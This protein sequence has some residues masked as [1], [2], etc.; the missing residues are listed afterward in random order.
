MICCL[1][2]VSNAIVQDA[3]LKS[4]DRDVS[5]ETIVT[6]SDTSAPAAPENATKHPGLRRIL[7]LAGPVV[8]ILVGLWLYLSGGQYVTEDD[9]YVGAANVTITPQVSGQVIRV[10]VATNQMVQQDQLLF[11]IDPEPFQIALDRA[12]ANLAEAS[13]KLQGLLLTYNQDQASVAQS[14]ADVTF[15]QQEFD[16][17]AALVKEKVETQAELDQAQRTLRVAQQAQRAAESG[18]AA[19]LAEF[20]GSVDK[21]IE[22]HAAY[23]AAKAEVE[24]AARNVRLT[25]VLAPFAGT[26][27]QVENIQPGSFLTVGQAAF[28]LIGLQSWIDANIKETDLTHIKV[29]DPATVTLDSYPDQ[30]LKAEV[31]S[32]TPA[33]GSVF[34][35]LPAQNASGNW[36]KVVQRMPVRLKITTEDPGVVLRDG[37]SATV[38]I[39]TGYHRSL[40]TLWRD[41]LG[42]V[43]ID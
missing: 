24:L 37:A 11:E 12:N 23:L 34:A 22:Q 4:S 2:P 28:S 31:Q 5:Q 27:T 10:A 38:S 6:A 16:R 30:L 42:M 21:P 20:G 40:A 39:D 3:A 43:G 25:K 35:L 26:V 15:A 32:I 1:G 41:L 19:T 9:A 33:T 29:G 14:K 13:E 7:L 36:V 18:A 17:V 8:A